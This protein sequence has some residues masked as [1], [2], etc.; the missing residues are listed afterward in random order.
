MVKFDSA[1]IARWTDAVNIWFRN[2]NDPGTRKDVYLGAEAWVIARL[3]GITEEAYEDRSVVDAHI[4]TVLKQIFPNAKFS[5]KYA[6]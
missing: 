6:Y 5:D 3:A 1:T 4:V 2:A